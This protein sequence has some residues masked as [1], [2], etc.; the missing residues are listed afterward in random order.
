MFVLRGSPLFSPPD[1]LS[2]AS[3]TVPVHSSC[4]RWVRMLVLPLFQLGRRQIRETERN[5]EG[6]A[7][8]LQKHMQQTVVGLIFRSVWLFYLLID[9][10]CTFM[11]DLG[12]WWV[13]KCSNWESLDLQSSHCLT[14]KDGKANFGRNP[15]W[16]T[17]AAQQQQQKIKCV[18]WNLNEALRKCHTFELI[19]K[20]PTLSKGHKPFDE[21]ESVRQNYSVKEVAC[22]TPRRNLKAS[23]SSDGLACRPTPSPL[24]LEKRSGRLNGV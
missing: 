12:P 21:W 9:L 22:K 2:T 19:V 4:Q 13:N 7:K 6:G 24:E 10:F 5:L 18:M 17:E 20:S 23:I 8:S 3:L 14:L 15:G 1:S 16:F 11:G